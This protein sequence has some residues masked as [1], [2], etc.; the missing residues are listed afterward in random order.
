MEKFNIALVDNNLMQRTITCEMIRAHLRGQPVRANIHEF[1]SGPELMREI[2][3]KGRYDIYI[4]EVSMPDMNGISIAEELRLEGDRGIIIYLSKDTKDAYQAF[5]VKARDY[6][7]KPQL[8]ERLNEALDEI[9]YELMHMNPSPVIEIKFKTGLMRV[10]VNNITYVDVVDRALCFHMENGR[11]LIGNCI[12]G[13]F[14]EAVEETIG[15]VP[16]MLDFVIAGSTQLLNLAYIMELGR[17]LVHLKTG[18]KIYI[19]RSA[20]KGLLEAWR[21]YMI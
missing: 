1:N 18:E 19:P 14:K 3:R 4:M 13:T 11:E 15:I 12:R 6:I 2:S 16:E 10:P 9:I 8:E 5:K 7:L 20:E 17:G 21:D